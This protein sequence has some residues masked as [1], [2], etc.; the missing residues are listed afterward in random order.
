MRR[1]AGGSRLEGIRAASH[2]LE[3]P[4]PSRVVSGGVPA[5]LACGLGRKRDPGALGAQESRSHVPRGVSPSS[6][7]LYS[8]GG[9]QR[10]AHWAL[11]TRPPKASLL[12][13]IK[14]GCPSSGP[15]GTAASA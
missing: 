8:A 6:W 1:A 14:S 9:Q 2:G 15:S 7:A 4:G 13:M 11:C 10:P 12:R 5:T 3:A